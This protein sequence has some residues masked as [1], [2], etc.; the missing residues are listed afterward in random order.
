M[1]VD[2]SQLVPYMNEVCAGSDWPE[3][4][5]ALEESEIAESLVVST[6]NYGEWCH[7][8]LIIGRINQYGV[9]AF[10]V[11]IPEKEKHLSL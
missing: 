6:S 7:L 5:K 2:A 1:V 8:L 10:K 11:V 4:K 9:F 3:K